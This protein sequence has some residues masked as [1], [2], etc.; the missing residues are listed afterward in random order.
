M[1]ARIRYYYAVM[2]CIANSIFY[3]LKVNMP[4][5]II[6]MVKSVKNQSIH[7]NISLECEHIEPE[8]KS[9]DIDGPYDWSTTQQ[10]MVISIF[11][12]GYLVANFPAGYF[13]DRFN[14]KKVLLGCIYANCVIT[15]LMPLAANVLEVMYVLRFLMGAASAA[16]LPIINVLIG[17]WL[18]YEEKGTWVAVIN[19]GFSI[20]TL[21]SILSAGYILDS[22]GWE[23]IFYIHGTLPLIW[24]FVYQIFFAESPEF[25]KYITEE[26]RQLI[27]NSYGHRSP[28]SKQMDVP[29]KA[30][31][32]SVPF[33]AL[34]LTNTLANFAWYFLLTNLPLYMNRILRFDIKSNATLNCL[35]YALNAILYPFLGKFLDYGRR[36]GFWTQTVARKIAVG[37][38]TIPPSIFLV[39][40]VNI[41]CERTASSA[42]LV[43][44]ITVCGVI[45]LGHLVNHND[46]APNYAGI[47]IG[48]TNTPGTI[49]AFLLP[50]LV[51]VLTESGHTIANWKIAFYIVVAAQVAGFIIFTFF[52][53]AQIQ[54]WNDSNGT[55][56]AAKAS[57]ATSNQS[58]KETVSKV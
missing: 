40:I 30:M 47:M 9:V 53:S 7:H 12:V 37:I 32:T 8:D 4:I 13:A 51:G 46:L 48:I 31:F 41:G 19:A 39:I 27:I 50:A 49:S 3:G 11:F 22:I 24:C 58:Q 10:G 36:R 42:L 1:A 25:Q 54:D 35:P 6:G 45:A 29:W 20:G 2:L 15:L 43:T 14:T 55:D 33:H 52:G 18:V 34:L 17:K 38:S 16:N 26:E 28:G 56:A 57:A 21:V 44:S 5:A 23:A